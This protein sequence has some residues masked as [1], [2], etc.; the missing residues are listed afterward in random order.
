MTITEADEQI[1]EQRVSICAS[2]STNVLKISMLY[3]LTTISR[4]RKHNALQNQLVE[5][6]IQGIPNFTP[7][8]IEVP[9]RTSAS[10]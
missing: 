4:K 9:N 7:A 5:A 10:Y 8:R 1:V 3:R 2:R 6:D